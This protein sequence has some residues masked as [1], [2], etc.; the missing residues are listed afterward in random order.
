ML[1]NKPKFRQVQYVTCSIRN[2]VIFVLSATKEVLENSYI[3]QDKTKVRYF[4]HDS[5]Y[6]I[7]YEILFLNFF[8]IG[9]LISLWSRGFTNFKKGYQNN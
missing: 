5:Q 4:L 3:R 7:D 8:R 2:Q 1:V 9:G 6:N